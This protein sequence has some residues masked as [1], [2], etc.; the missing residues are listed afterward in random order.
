MSAAGHR[1]ALQRAA[2]LKKIPVEQLRLGMYLHAFEGAWVDH[3]FWR[4]KFLIKSPADLQ[5]IRD[6]SIRECWID[7]AQ[8]ADVRDDGS[9]TSGAAVQGPILG[10]AETSPGAAGSEQKPIGAPPATAKATVG[11]ELPRARQICDRLHAAAMAVFAEA[12][13]GQL[14]DASACVPLVHDVVE[15]VFRH[16]EALT[17]LVRL[18][19][20]RTDMCMHGVAVCALVASV[21]RQ[22][23]LGAEQVREAALGGLLLDIG[24]VFIPSEVLDTRGK[25]D[26]TQWAMVRAH[27]ERGRDAL[28]ALEPALT[29]GV[30]DICLHHHE[31]ADGSGYPHRLSGEQI[32]LYARIAAVCDVY[33]ALTSQRPHR[34]AMDPAIAVQA[35]AQWKGQFDPLVFQAFVRAVGI[36]PIGSLVRLQSGRLAVVVEQNPQSLLTP[37]VKAFYSARSQVHLSPELIDLSRPLASDRIAQR[38]LATQWGFRHL[39]RL[40][41]G[42]AAG[43]AT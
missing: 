30:L 41:A 39:D 19:A 40:W 31:R 9:P 16:S 5:A 27:A 21:A 3:P 13:L 33:D 37:V 38:E 11:E 8:G 24:K 43:I 29:D 4:T 2:M 32:G 25:L 42:D 36:Y 20:S 18:K 35:M 17:G 15:S 14:K 7:A 28:A 6:S 10:G 1:L 12:R 22:L 23:G 34:A 26:A